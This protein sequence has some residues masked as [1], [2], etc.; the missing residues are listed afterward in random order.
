MLRLYGNGIRE[1][2]NEWMNMKQLAKTEILIKKT[3]SQRLLVC[4]KF[5]MDI[6]GIE[7]G[8]RWWQVMARSSITR[9]V[10]DFFSTPPIQSAPGDISLWKNR[11]RCEDDNSVP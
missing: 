3:L 7:P 4:H 10:N 11:L 6:P 2:M 9:I 1:W 8:P 5:Y